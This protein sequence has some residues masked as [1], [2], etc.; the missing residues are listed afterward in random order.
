MAIFFNDT[1]ERV[2][3]L[4]NSTPD[5]G[6]GGFDYA[7]QSSALI[8]TV[9]GYARKEV[10]SGYALAVVGYGDQ[11]G[12]YGNPTVCS[13]SS[14]LR[15][16]A[17]A[18]AAPESGTAFELLV[19][20]GGVYFQASLQLTPNG[21]VFDVTMNLSQFGGSFNQTLSFSG[22]TP[23]TDYMVVLALQD[24][25][26]SLTLDGQTLLNS[27]PYSDTL[28]VTFLRFGV[29][30][31]F[32]V[33]Q[34]SGADS[35]PN[36]IDLDLLT[37]T[38]IVS[39][40]FTS[41]TVASLITSSAVVA[42]L[43]ND[44]MAAVDDLTN[45]GVVRSQALPDYTY[46]IVDAGVVSS[47]VA[48]A[49]STAAVSIGV[50]SSTTSGTRY[51]VSDIAATGRALSRISAVSSGDVA[52]SAG[53]AA[54]AVDGV[55]LVVDHLTSVGAASSSATGAASSRDDIRTGGSLASILTQRLSAIDDTTERGVVSSRALYDVLMQA[56]VMNAQ[57]HAMSRYDGLP[58]KSVAV[59]AGRV[60]ALGDTGFFEL[61]SDADDGV[62]V[63]S[64]AVTGLLKLG[65]DKL[66]RLGDIS[67]G[68]ASKGP[69][70]FTITQ[71]GSNTGSYTYALPPRTA[72]APRG[73]RVVPGKGLLSKYYQFT[74]AGQ[75]LGL[76]YAQVEVGS[77]TTRRI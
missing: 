47:Q 49:V 68:Y 64:K 56:W 23:S 58:Y 72:D 66:K 17:I 5:Q 50:A 39:S 37:S 44:A 1:F 36:L 63:K 19:A 21:A 9:G 11:V 34:L 61:D 31:G 10:G 14:V 15:T 18:D 75:S 59:I 77:S 74:I 43:A 62:A 30:G 35:A 27:L 53:V 40:L 12:D 13:I 4:A 46:T 32:S 16:A 20:V 38:G 26:Q 54:S 65:T 3:P 45:Q 8:E 22:L 51:A 73:G 7:Q 29:D 28:G 76:D 41:S 70:A 57:T 55:S 67:I 71:Y 6:F 33:G 60:I 52:V 24:G 2:G 25:L 69:V 42:S 48:S